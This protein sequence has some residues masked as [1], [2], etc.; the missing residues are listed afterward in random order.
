MRAI[1]TRLIAAGEGMGRPLALAAFAIAAG[2]LAF[3]PTAYIGV[4]QLGIIAG[5][6]MLVALALNLT[7]LPA[8]I[9]LLAPQAAEPGPPPAEVHAHRRL[10]P[11]ASGAGCWASRSARRSVCAALLP[12]LR[13]DFNPIHLRDPKSRVDRHLLRP[14]RATPTSRPTRWRPCAPTWRRRRRWRRGRCSCREVADARTAP[15]SSR[16]TSPPSWRPSPTPRSCS[17]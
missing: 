9:V 6:G 7:L 1:A 5:V 13:F 8:L 14:D 10:H 3:A 4:S 15:T 16:P 2:F 12:L 17:T 11:R